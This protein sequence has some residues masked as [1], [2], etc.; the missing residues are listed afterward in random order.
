VNE[1]NI[2]RQPDK[3]NPN[4]TPLLPPPRDPCAPSSPPSR[5]PS[6]MKDLSPYSRDHGRRV[7]SKRKSLFF[8]LNF[9]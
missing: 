3:R 5:V 1:S 7:L 8:V 4:E 2:L 6:P 9:V